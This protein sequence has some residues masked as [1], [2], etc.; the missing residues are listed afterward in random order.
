MRWDQE[1]TPNPAQGG[2]NTEW[3]VPLRGGVRGG[4]VADRFVERSAAS[5]RGRRG[6]VSSGL[7]FPAPLFSHRSLPLLPVPARRLAD[8][9]QGVLLRFD[10]RLRCLRAAFDFLLDDFRL[11]GGSALGGAGVLGRIVCGAGA[12][13]P[14]TIRT[15]YGG[16]GSLPLDRPGVLSQRTVLFAVFVAR[17]R[18]RLFE[19]AASFPGNSPRHVR[20]RPG[21]DAAG[22]LAV[23][24][25]QNARRPSAGYLSGRARLRSPPSGGTGRGAPT[26]RGSSGR[27][28]D[29][30]S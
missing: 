13:M 16:V 15:A 28:A 22:R 11:A 1:S 29:G 2:S 27:V 18:L 5:G 6:R 8:D 7:R 10:R 21:A 3:P 19:L 17:H 20:S 23:V 12:I 26:Q 9:A 25:D 4:F 24:A 14:E 30:I